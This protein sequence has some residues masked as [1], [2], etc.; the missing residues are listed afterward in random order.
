MRCVG[1]YCVWLVS[2]SLNAQV[3]P[4]VH[5]HCR[6]GISHF[7]EIAGDAELP[8]DYT[9]YAGTEGMYLFENAAKE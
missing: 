8:K 3:V 2:W 9:P 5:A 7:W 1:T 6:R 4:D